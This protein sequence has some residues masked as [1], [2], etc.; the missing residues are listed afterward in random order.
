MRGSCPSNFFA[1]N[2]LRLYSVQPRFVFDRLR[3]EGVYQAEPLK[4]PESSLNDRDCSQWR[5]AYDWLVEQMVN[6]GMARPGP[7]VYPVWAWHQWAGP[8][9]PCPDLRTSSLK[10]WAERERHVLLTLNVP[11]HEVLVSDYDAWH[12]CLNYWFYGT[13]REAQAFERRCKQQGQSYYRN[14]PLGSAELHHEVRA[15][16]AQALDIERS[17]RLTGSKKSNQVL[18]A[19][20]WTLKH[21]HVVS[22]V[23]FGAGRPRELLVRAGS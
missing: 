8:G 5:M 4:N 14:K 3:I 13:Q 2:D 1:L 10:S 15:S 20:F 21:E 16:W 19:T 18:Q 23:E 17:R 9:R 12:W 22:A 6:R 11:D 7:E